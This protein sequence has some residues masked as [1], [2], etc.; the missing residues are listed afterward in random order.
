MSLR[1][2]RHLLRY[3]LVRRLLLKLGS[4]H[5]DSVALTHFGRQEVP[6]GAFRP[7]AT[8]GSFGIACRWAASRLG[9]RI[10]V[11]G[12]RIAH[13]NLMSSA[14]S[15]TFCSTVA[16]LTFCGMSTFPKF[17]GKSTGHSV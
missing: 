9:L 2:I 15:A 16:I 6:I 10:R 11:T 12:F 4:D 1:L 3:G 8:L 13:L 7:E 5:E 17:L 14:C